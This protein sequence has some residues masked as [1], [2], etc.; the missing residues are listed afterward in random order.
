MTHG[1]VMCEEKTP[2]CMRHGSFGY[3]AVDP[4]TRKTSEATW[5]S[6]IEMSFVSC[7]EWVSCH[8]THSLVMK[9]CLLFW[10]KR[11]IH[12]RDKR[13]IYYMRNSYMQQSSR[14][15]TCSLH[16]MSFVSCNEGVSCRVMRGCLVMKRSVSWDKRLMHYMKSASCRG[17]KECLARKRSLLSWDNRLL[18][19]MK[20]ASCRGMN[21]SLVTKQIS[22]VSL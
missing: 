13:L 5:D 20:W 6:F 9:R 22:W 19:Y 2:P 15:E 16:E 10:D 4:S 8:E 1:S 3:V 12:T 7:N 17:M 18:H 14:Q 11:P 21:E